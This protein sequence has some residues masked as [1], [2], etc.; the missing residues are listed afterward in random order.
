MIEADVD[1]PTCRLGRFSDPA[2]V[3][4]PDPSRFLDEYMRGGVESLAGVLC[5]LSMRHCDDDDIEL[6]CQQLVKRC[7]GQP[8][9]T[10]GKRL[11]C[12]RGEI[13]AGDKF[14]AAERCRTFVADQPTADDPDAKRRPFG[15]RCGH[16][17]STP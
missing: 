16:V 9:E 12:A 14:V 11:S 5:E 6:V 7:A 4:D 15:W 1:S 17:Y 8:T 13:E 2:H 3:V 10:I